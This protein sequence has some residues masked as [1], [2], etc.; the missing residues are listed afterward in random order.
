MKHNIKNLLYKNIPNFVSLLR[1][2]LSYVFIFAFFGYDDNMLP[3]LFVIILSVITD[4]AD[5]ALARKLDAV[6]DIGKLIDPYADKFMQSV[7]LACLSVKG[8][9]PFWLAALYLFKEL[10]MV[11]L[12]YVLLKR[13]RVVVCSNVFGKTATV[14]FYVI[15]TF[16]LL[17][18]SDLLFGGAYA[19]ICLSVMVV[20]FVPAVAYLFRYKKY[21]ADIFAANFKNSNNIK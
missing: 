18:P 1:I 15:A 9:L 7:V 4:V 21:F 16:L 13:Y 10:I 6:T 20:C 14:T 11:L 8:A 19:L 5:G 12:G 3:A 2:P 17:F